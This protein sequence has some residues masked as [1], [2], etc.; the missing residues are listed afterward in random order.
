MLNLT[1]PNCGITA[2][3]TDLHC[4]GQAH[5][6]RHGAGANDDDLETYLF[7]RNNPKGVHFERWRHVY[8]CGKWFHA[9]RCTMTLEVFGT[10]SAQTF[11]PPKSLINKIKKKRPE[12]EGFVK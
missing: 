1:C 9:A 3:E 5:I 7:M 11:V 6:T 4:D 12:F 10:Y 8:G 2:D